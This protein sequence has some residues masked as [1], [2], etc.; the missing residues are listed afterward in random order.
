VA[1]IVAAYF[2]GMHICHGVKLPYI[3]KFKT[4]FEIQ[5]NLHSILNSPNINPAHQTIAD[6]KRK[7]KPYPIRFFKDN[8]FWK[9]GIMKA[10][11]KLVIPK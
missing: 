11:T 3:I 1:H 5:N 6:P 10:S 4:V 9:N 2:F 7:R 8:P